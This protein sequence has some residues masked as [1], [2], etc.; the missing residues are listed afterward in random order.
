MSRPP[1]TSSGDEPAD[2]G[3]TLMRILHVSREIVV[4]QSRH[5]KANKLDWGFLDLLKDAEVT[6]ADWQQVSE[7]GSSTVQSAPT[8]PAEGYSNQSIHSM[9]D[10]LQKHF[11]SF[12]MF[13]DVPA[14]VLDTEKDSEMHLDVN[15][16]LDQKAAV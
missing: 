8:K 2:N 5:Q 3:I 13:E 10:A 12:P 14:P 1:H 6:T 4:E 15:L 16:M 9:L 11:G 7:G